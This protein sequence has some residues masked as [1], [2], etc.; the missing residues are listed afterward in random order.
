MSW[1]RGCIYYNHGRT[2]R[3]Y[4]NRGKRPIDTINEYLKTVREDG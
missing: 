4:C 2:H 3:G 1:M